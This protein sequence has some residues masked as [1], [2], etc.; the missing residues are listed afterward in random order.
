MISKF[1]NNSNYSTLRIQK[2]KTKRSK[3]TKSSYGAGLRAQQALWKT[4]ALPEIVEFSKWGLSNWQETRHH[5]SCHRFNNNN[6]LSS[7][8]LLASVEAR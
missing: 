1:A 6:S 7:I 5:L 2:T 8:V 3:I 4:R